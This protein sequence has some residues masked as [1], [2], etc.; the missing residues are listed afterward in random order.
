MN[1]KKRDYIIL[2]HDE[3]RVIAVQCELKGMYNARLLLNGGNME[4]ETSVDDYIED[5]IA[6][7]G[8][9]TEEE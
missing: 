5:I 9:I 3:L 7:G 1:T 2:S 8:L 4:D 6:N